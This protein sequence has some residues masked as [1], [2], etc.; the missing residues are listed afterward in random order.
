MACSALSVEITANNLT[1]CTF[2]EVCCYHCGKIRL[3]TA[4]EPTGRQLCPICSMPSEYRRLG[5]G[6]TLRS[7][8]FWHRIREESFD[9]RVT[10]KRFRGIEKS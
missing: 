5:M 7:L 8:P 10:L 4:R 6:G 2:L 3:A 1:A 9:F